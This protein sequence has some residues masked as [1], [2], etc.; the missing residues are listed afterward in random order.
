MLLKLHG[1]FGTGNQ[2]RIRAKKSFIY[3]LGVLLFESSFPVIFG[4]WSWF[5]L[6]QLL[7]MHTVA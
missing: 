1:S 5:L 3:V 4:Y 6:E 7:Y 2:S